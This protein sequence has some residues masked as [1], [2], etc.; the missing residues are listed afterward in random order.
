[1]VLTEKQIRKIKRSKKLGRAGYAGQVYLYK[2]KAWKFFHKPVTSDTDLPVN[3]DGLISTVGVGTRFVCFPEILATLAG[4]PTDE[5]IGY[6]RRAVKKIDNMEKL[7]SRD[8]NINI[9]KLEKDFILM[10]DLGI[11]PIDVHASQFIESKDG[12]YIIDTDNYSKEEPYDPLVAIGILHDALL[13]YITFCSKSKRIDS[14]ILER[15]QGRRR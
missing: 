2:N 3:Y 5:Y 11:T 6:K 9:T 10:A 8:L 7:S 14:I 15:V 13:N 1:M 4:S 12:L